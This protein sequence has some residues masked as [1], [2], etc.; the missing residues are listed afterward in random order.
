MSC[1]IWFWISVPGASVSLANELG[2]DWPAARGPRGDG[3]SLTSSLSSLRTVEPGT[4]LWRRPFSG[5]S[6]PAVFAGRVFV[7]GREGSAEDPFEVAA[8][9]DA[10][11]GEQVWR[12]RYPLTHSGVP[13][14]RAAN[15][16]PAVDPETGNIYTLGSG[17]LLHCFDPAG[18]VLWRLDLSERLGARAGYSGR[19]VAPL[20]DEDLLVVTYRTPGNE[21]GSSRICYL[22]LEKTTGD[23]RWI[24]RPGQAV[25]EPSWIGSPVV[26][27]VEGRRLLVTA[28]ADGY[29]YAMFLRTGVTAWRFRFAA[30]G[31]QPLLVA[32]D[33]TIY[34]THASREAGSNRRGGVLAIDAGG[35]GDVSRSHLRWRLN[36]A[37]STHAPTLHDERL[38]VVDSQ[39]GLHAVT[40][41]TGT[42]LWQLRLARPI[43]APAVAV[44]DDLCV[45]TD[46][47][48]LYLL[49]GS[50]QA[51]IAEAALRLYEGESRPVPRVP[52]PAPAYGHL[53]L[54]TATT[55]Q[56]LG[57]EGS[58]E[59]RR[60]TRYRPSASGQTS[61]DSRP[62]QIQVLP[63]Y[64]RLK[65]GQALKLRAR[66]YDADGRFIREIQSRWQWS[67]MAGKITHVGELRLGNQNGVGDVVALYEGLKGHA[68]VWADPAV[69][70]LQD[71]EQDDLNQAPVG[72][73]GA[74]WLQIKQTGANRVLTAGATEARARHRMAYL[75]GDEQTYQSIQAQVRG[76]PRH[77]ILPDIGVSLRGYV[78]SLMG[79]HGRV[80]LSRGF[81]HERI[82]H[83][84]A[85]PWQPNIWYTLK[86]EVQQGE[87]GLVVRG[88]VWPADAREPAE[89][90]IERLEKQPGEHHGVPGLYHYSAAEAQFDLV[91]VR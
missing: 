87:H 4:A 17:Y 18:E 80:R 34:L 50:G 82:G 40:V 15:A 69:P 39:G 73:V 22:A 86:L 25:E 8:A 31:V 90:T 66:A 38:L 12:H 7:M 71:F 48:A 57:D 41:D 53:F 9:F 23:P 77:Q 62:A 79:Q 21:P 64:A 60:D 70:L 16:S 36:L 72:W 28:E 51:P 33:R 35:S 11:T 61:P 85:F 78:F 42:R 2:N 43:A 59:P 84:K 54:V 56:A 88:K 10:A 76:L 44:G 68:R 29:V 24:A 89:W 13:F 74:E 26:C 6:T 55:L 37:G 58:L 5:R 65:P 52:A 91:R 75:G 3:S 32:A 47:G 30:R 46:D 81:G 1:L 67:G 63:P 27:E 19:L 49:D 45:V 20:V 14:L 83:L